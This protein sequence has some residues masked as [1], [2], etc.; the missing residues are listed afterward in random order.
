MAVLGMFG[1]PNVEK[2]KTKGDVGGI[3][4]ALSYKKNEGVRAAAATALADMGTS[5][6][7]EPLIGA[8]A[9]EASQVRRAAAEALDRLHWAPDEGRAGA[10]FHIA[11][12]EWE[13]CTAMGA[14]AVEALLTV[15]RDADPSIAQEA[16][17]AMERIGAPAVGAL[18]A[19]L[20]SGDVSARGPAAQVLARIGEPAVSPLIAALK[21]GDQQ[22]REAAASALR[23]IRGPAIGPLSELLDDPNADVRGQ[24]ASALGDIG[25]PRPLPALMRMLG[26]TSSV[27]R[28]AAADALGK[29]ADSRKAP[30]VFGRAML[31]QIQAGMQGV[32]VSLNANY[33]LAMVAGKRA[34]YFFHGGP[35]RDCDA[36]PESTVAGILLLLLGAL[37]DAD[38][39]VRDAAAIALAKVGDTAVAPLLGFL[40]DQD[41]SVRRHVAIA[42][43]GIGDTRAVGPLL[44]A[45]GDTSP[46]VRASAALALGMMEDARCID[47]LIKVLESDQEKLV[48]TA[49]AL[50]LGL[51]IGQAAVKI[52]QRRLQVPDMGLVSACSAALAMLGHPV[53]V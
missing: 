16:A 32:S 26:E 2:L 44:N 49:A 31:A 20:T 1:P 34:V 7:M 24:A 23:T 15:L 50:S 51:K 42:L 14:P 18:I 48:W 47:P 10:A 21:D 35:R 28:A 8:L 27:N 41:A 13:R 38:E 53:N 52:L 29:I 45:L 17:G 5:A 6:A 43:G 37:R 3:L 22:L 9:D 30:S 40:T 19:S 12:G 4:K 36:P 25:D 46:P 11:K 39:D 33:A